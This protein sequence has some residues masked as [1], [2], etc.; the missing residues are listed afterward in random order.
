M[1]VLHTQARLVHAARTAVFCALALACWG[2]ASAPADEID[3]YLDDQRQRL[4]LPGL[5]VAVVRDGRIVKAQG[6]G[7]ASLEL[8][9][10]ATAATVYEIG[11]LTKQFT[12]AA[13]LMLAEE[14][15]VGLDDPVTKYFPEAPG[16][17]ARVTLRH[18][19][20]HTSG[21]RNH[22]AVPQ[23]MGAFKSDLLMDV[24]P[25]RDDL[26]RM[27]YALPFEFAPG[28]TWA[29]DNTG[30]YLLGLLVER[31]SGT[32][33]WEFLDARIFG[34]LGMSSTR[35]TDPRDVVA[36]R[37]SGYDWA[38]E[39]FV[40]RPVLPPPVGFSAGALLSTVEDLARWDAALRDGRLLSPSLREAMWT[41]ALL[42][43]G[44]VAPVD[45][46][47]GWFVTRR[48][49]RR[50][51]HHGGGT[52][53]FSSTICRF[54][55]EGL[56]VIIAANRG[57]RMLDQLAIE[58][59]GLVLPHLKR[60]SPPVDP[61]PARTR[62]LAGV[63]KDL[64]AG[65]SAPEALTPPLRTFLGTTSGR[66]WWEWVASH[67]ELRSLTFSEEEGAGRARVVRYRAVVG[68]NDY[69]LTARLEADGR[70]SQLNWW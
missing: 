29:Y 59:A 34:P 18:L 54:V 68:D 2:A 41:A 48:R 11:S 26:L 7:R 13:V 25:A 1:P 43:D 40:N 8:E 56:T 70:L 63:V 10:P 42:R 27:F 66:G 36:G 32:S 22:V 39:R 57:D 58:V 51:V 33:Y 38:G 14:G 67:G 28:E 16:T 53:G 69:W 12:A 61:D 37:A 30:Y 20:T 9:V 64:L 31:A 60:A 6:Y 19:L 49:G 50:V 4:R 15:R 24:T 62:R 35:S 23:F 21:L 52:P 65:Q 17:W 3:R 44:S 47:F 46:G 45:Y 55:D 5:S